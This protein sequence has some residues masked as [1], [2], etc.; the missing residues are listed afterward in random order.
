M[1][2]TEEVIQRKQQQQ[3]AYA[4]GSRS[5]KSSATKDVKPKIAPAV[6]F[7][8][9]DAPLVSKERIKDILRRLDPEQRLD[10]DVETVSLSRCCLLVCLIPNSLKSHL[11][12]VGYGTGS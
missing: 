11:N 7:N 6:A 10:A 9:P 8:S 12:L 5:R 1:N 4:S 3:Q 2:I